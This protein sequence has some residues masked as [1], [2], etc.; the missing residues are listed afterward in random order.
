MYIYTHVHIYRRVVRR[1]E[2]AGD[3]RESPQLPGNGDSV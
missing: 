2:H 3:D 1:G